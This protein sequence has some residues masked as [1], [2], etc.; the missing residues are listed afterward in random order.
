MTL[1]ELLR[2]TT[3]SA[4]IVFAMIEIDTL[5]P[6]LDLFSETIPTQINEVD[7]DT[8]GL[9]GD[10]VAANVRSADVVYRTNTSEYGVFIN[11]VT[12]EEAAI[13]AARVATAVNKLFPHDDARSYSV[14]IGLADSRTMQASDLIDQARLDLRAR[15]RGQL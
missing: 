2:D 1:E 13:V 5:L 8:M 7:E 10:A 4:T 6:S 3:R 11:D 14:A 15:Q 9:I 12:M